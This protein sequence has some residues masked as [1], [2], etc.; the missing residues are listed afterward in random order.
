MGLISTN[1]SYPSRKLQ[2]NMNAGLGYRNCNFL[3]LFFLFLSFRDVDNVD[4][5]VHKSRTRLCAFYPAEIPS[6]SKFKFYVNCFPNS[7]TFMAFL[8]KPLVKP[9]GVLL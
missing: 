8:F 5:F 1:N 6:G 9:F 4:N 7:L 3:H 2:V